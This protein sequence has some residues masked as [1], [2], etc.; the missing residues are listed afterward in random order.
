MDKYVIRKETADDLDELEKLY[1]SLNDYLEQNI[2]Y[3][4]W[5]KG[6]YPVRENAVDGIKNENLYVIEIN[7]QIAG[8]VILSHEPEKSYNKALWKTENNYE[9]I[10]VIRTFAVHPKFMKNN[11]GFSLMKFAE[12]FGKENGMKSIHLD[13]AIQNA[14]AISL[15][16]KLGYEYI[17]TVDLDLNISWLK[18][19]K[20]YEL[21]IFYK[22]FVFTM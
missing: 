9:N 8:T 10:I 5:R 16:K 12:K 21:Q 19:F 13:V 17:D 2:N 20:L 4:G 1:D 7:E 18:W 22:F 14:P 11:A 15:Y 3:P 6:L